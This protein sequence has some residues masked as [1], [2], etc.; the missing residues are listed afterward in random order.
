MK[1]LMIGLFAAI[2]MTFAYASELPVTSQM[3][4]QNAEQAQK[5]ATPDQLAGQVLCC[6]P[7]SGGG[8]CCKYQTSCF[9]GF[10]NGCFCS[11][12][13]IE[14]EPSNSNATEGKVRT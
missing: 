7:V 9:G 1:K 6:C 12:H 11:G 8:T 14:S 10:V 5:N 13:S 3:N 2:S 4:C